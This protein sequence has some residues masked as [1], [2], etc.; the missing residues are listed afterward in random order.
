MLRKFRLLLFETDVFQIF[1]GHERDVCVYL[2]STLCD[3]GNKNTD[4]G[5]RA[6]NKIDKGKGPMVVVNDESDVLMNNIIEEDSDFSDSDYNVDF[7]DNDDSDD[8]NFDENIDHGVDDMNTTSS[9]SSGKN[10][11]V[12]S[13]DDFDSDLGSEE[14]KKEPS[15]PV[16]NPSEIFQPTFDIARATTNAEFDR[17]MKEM[18]ELDVKA[19]EW[20][21]DKPPYQ[22][23]RS[24]FKGYSKCDI[25]LNNLCESFNS[26]ILEARE[27]PIL[28]MLEWIREY[29]MVKMQ[30]NR[31]RAAKRW[32]DKKIC[33]KIKKIVDKNVDKAS[34]CI[35][36]KAN[37]WNYEISCYDGA[38]YTVDLI[39]HT[40]SCRKWELSGIPCKHG[41]SAI[42]A[43]VLDPVDFVHSC[44]Q[45]A[46]YT[47]VYE[48]CM[49]PM[50]GASM[51]EKTGYIPPLPPDFGKKRGRPK[52]SR[53]PS[54]D[55]EL[56]KK[57]KEEFPPE[58]E[59]IP[60]PQQQ[61]VAEE[62]TQQPDGPHC[63]SL[64]A[65]LSQSHKHSLR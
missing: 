16:F 13:D 3:S 48:P 14:D 7:D 52:R 55:E 24:H 65:N 12:I 23:S 29:M 25:L 45:V 46:T 40:C 41:M 22:W 37:D 38:R 56:K 36:I 53:K 43:Q 4:E 34:D 10:G 28:T 33:P 9:D 54:A 39:A 64:I 51:W 59:D 42:C 35:P 5:D 31:D 60:L 21:S 27:K 26:S 6:V 57:K 11:L 8:N 62:L 20:L 15:Y 17:A 63:L 61:S 50:D 30:Q 32:G 2:D 1:D 18:E 58:D 19:L 49:M 44:Y 47:K